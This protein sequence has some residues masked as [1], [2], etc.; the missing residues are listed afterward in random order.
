[1]RNALSLPPVCASPG[2][3]A[4]SWVLRNTLAAEKPDL[5]GTE[6][7]TVSI[8]CTVQ[9]YGWAFPL[10]MEGELQ[11]ISGLLDCLL[12]FNLQSKNHSPFPAKESILSGAMAGP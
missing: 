7:V 5:L 8:P 2:K 10:K 6:P 3:P 11:V 9:L 12:V 1:M 4:S